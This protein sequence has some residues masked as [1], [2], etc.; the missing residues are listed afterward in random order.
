M[1]RKKIFFIGIGISFTLIF[2][3]IA[4]F[5]VWLGMQSAQQMIL[6]KLNHAIP[7]RISWEDLDFSLLTGR[8]DLRKAVVD[9]PLDDRIIEAERI[10][11]NLSLPSLIAGNLRAESLVLEKPRVR[12]KSDAQGH[13]NIVTAFSDP[14]KPKEESSPGRGMPF[15]ILA[16]NIQI[17]DGF[18]SYEKAGKNSE[19]PAEHVTVRD[20]DLTLRNGDF[21]DRTGKAE[22]KIGSGDADIAGLKTDFREVHL[23][24]DMEKGNFRNTD[25]ELDSDLAKISMSGSVSDT[26]SHPMP[27]IDLNLETGLENIRQSFSLAADLTGPVR[28][29]LKVS[30]N[31][32]DPEAELDLAYGGGSLAGN[33]VENLAAVCELKNRIL[34]ISKLDISTASGNIQAEGQA[35]FAKAFPNGFFSPQRDMNILNYS[36]SVKPA[37]IILDQLPVQKTGFGGI[38]DGVINVQGSGISSEHLKISADTEITAGKFSVEKVLNPT[39]VRLT[40]QALM[41]KGKLIFQSI[42][43]NADTL[44][45]SGNGDYTPAS[46]EIQA[47]LKLDAA[48]LKTTL[49]SLNIKDVIGKLGLNADISGTLTQPL[50][51][52][53]LKGEGLGFKNISIGNLQAKTELDAEGMV[54]IPELNL[55]NRDSGLSAVGK[56]R[57]FEKGLHLHPD[58][59]ADIMLSLRNIKAGNFI[60]QE[61]VKGSADGTIRVQG[62]IMKPVADL[63]LTGKSL[64]FGMNQIGDA[65]TRIHFAKGKA[66]VDHLRVKNR[67]SDL[68]LSGDIQILD[69]QMK[70]LSDPLFD[71]NLASSAFFP[72]DFTDQIK[73]KLNFTAQGKGSLNAPDILLKLEGKDLAAG[74]N[75]IGNLNTE[76]AFAQGIVTVKHLNLENRKSGLRLSGTARVTAPQSLKPLDDPE[77]DL[78]ISKCT[79]YPEDFTDG[80]KGKLQLT[81]QAKG[82]KSSPRAEISI[83]GEDLSAP[84]GRIGN[85]QAALRFAEGKLL[86]DKMQVRNGKS[87]LDMSGSATVLNPKT[88]RPL[89]EP[90]FDIKIAGDTLFLEDFIKGIKGK[91]ALSGHV[92]GTKNRPQGNITVEGKKIDTGMQKIEG[93]QL[94]SRLDGERVNIDSFLVTV[95]PGENIVTDGWISPLRR[96]Y[97]LRMTSEG[98]SLKNIDSLSDQDFGKGKISFSLAGKGSFDNPNAEGDIKINGLTM[99]KKVLDDLKIRVDIKDQTARIIGNA[100]F[101]LNALYHLKSKDFNAK[102]RFDRTDLTPFFSLAGREDLKGSLTGI[103][104]AA[105][106]GG[107][108]EDIRAVA[109]IG[110]LEIFL[111][112]AE[113]IRTS[114]AKVVFENGE[115]SAPGIRLALLREGS[116]NIAGKGNIRGPLDFRADGEIPLQVLAL[117]NEDLEDLSG[118]LS[119]NADIKGSPEKPDFRAGIVLNS[120][121]MTVPGLMQKLHGLNGNIDISHDALVL[122]N[123]AGKLDEGSFNLAGN[124]ALDRFRPGRMQIELSGNRIPVSVPDTADILF[125]THLTLK[126]TQEKSMLEGEAVLLEGEYYKDVK[127]GLLENLGKIGQKKRTESVPGSKAANPFLKNMRMNITV[128]SRNPFVVDNNIALLTL[129]PDLKVSG[130]AV[131]PLIGGRAGVESG[132]IIYQTRE[133]EIQ[134]GVIDFLNPYKIEPTIDIKGE[135]EIRDWTVSLAVSGTPDNLKFELSSNPQEEHGDILSLLILGKTTAELVKGEGS[136]T[137]ATQV[138]ADV[139]AEKMGEKLKDA[140]ALDT[141]ELGYTEGDTS[142]DSQIRVTVGKELSRRISVKYGVETRSGETVQKAGTEYKFLENLIVNAFQDSSGVFGGEIIFRLEFR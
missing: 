76:L 125:N 62:P 101:D 128:K 28:L 137:S 37:G 7:G 59:P 64:A 14:Q 105:G 18:F 139:L 116:L 106:N 10:S 70:P 63:E 121:G 9:G 133:F 117:L 93:V 114:N 113:L 109:D 15:N 132:T 50:A 29:H 91:L 55:D 71:L 57:V 80:L 42:D 16:K 30:G 111:K 58:L 12:M 26:F 127:I 104:E 1:T 97:D 119:L 19:S 122:K 39:D 99:K 102:L 134:K 107:K 90:E 86:I 43:L 138:L 77:F 130:T 81:A 74:K 52:V 8:I 124:I 31:P 100:Y 120:L 94:K 84:S 141:L 13:L 131:Q 53:E 33:R 22:L 129:K 75:R 112:E 51:K 72:E 135:A 48:D 115:I 66:K 49:A 95:A 45:L 11:L 68:N 41:E 17:K 82:K 108:P 20:I 136:S 44:H 118:S 40:A 88:N 21:A 126:G 79:L 23:S 73:G 140:T 87:A 89:A 24:T 6:A 34:H 103:I 27:D 54:H 123:I 65:D 36:F 67:K 4:G 78:E 83:Q 60:A 2:L 46:K 5:R 142:E 85:L 98:I 69:E 35:D 32:N 47:K 25:L 92:S 3:T 61:N 38:L 96:S 56:I 110:A